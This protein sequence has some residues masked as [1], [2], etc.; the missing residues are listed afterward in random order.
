VIALKLERMIFTIAVSVE[1]RRDYQ[2][3]AGIRHAVSSIMEEEM[4]AR[5]M[6]H[7][8]ELVYD[9]SGKFIAAGFN[10]IKKSGEA[11]RNR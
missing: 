2:G 5:I 11:G 4:K 9:E 1:E 10:R 3:C 7:F 8:E 6:H